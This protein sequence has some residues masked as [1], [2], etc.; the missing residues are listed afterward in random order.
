MTN[1]QE[2]EEIEGYAAGKAALY[3]GMSPQDAIN[4]PVFW[5][6]WALIVSQ[7]EAK[8]RDQKESMKPK[9]K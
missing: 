5:V 9:K 6:D 7:V 3:W 4:L 1:G 8:V 2:G